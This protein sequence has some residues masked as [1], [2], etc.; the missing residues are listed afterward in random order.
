MPAEAG[1]DRVLRR[2][3]WRAEPTLSRH[4]DW[5]PWPRS[6]ACPFFFGSAVGEVERC[7]TCQVRGG[8]DGA[9]RLEMVGQV[10]R[11]RTAR[12][13][14]CSIAPVRR[15]RRSTATPRAWNVFHDTDLRCVRIS[16][17]REQSGDLGQPTFGRPDQPTEHQLRA[18]LLTVYA[19]KTARIKR[20]TSEVRD[21]T[22]GSL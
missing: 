14:S 20:A 15:P 3:S 6:E 7:R 12:R 18:N 13:G 16:D 22:S 17:L 10:S 21:Q 8:R 4:G 11:C 19:R 9:I 1:E 2:S 5:Q